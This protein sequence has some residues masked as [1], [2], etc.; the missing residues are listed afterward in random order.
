MSEEALSDAGEGTE[1]DADEAGCG[2]ASLPARGSAEESD[3][4]NAVG[5][6]AGAA[7]SRGRDRGED[8]REPFGCLR[9]GGKGAEEHDQLEVDVAHGRGDGMQGGVRD[10]AEGRQDTGEI[11]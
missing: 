5:S 1:V 2:D 10:C 8:G 9:S 6:A 3:P 11:G 4:S 7:Y